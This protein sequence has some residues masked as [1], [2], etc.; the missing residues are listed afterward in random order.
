M[1]NT[2]VITILSFILSNSLQASSSDSILER[3]MEKLGP[4]LY[5]N[6]HNKGSKDIYIDKVKIWFSTCSAK[7]GEPDRIYRIGRTNRSYTDLQS[8]VTTSWNHKGAYCY[9]IDSNFV[10]PRTIKSIKPKPKSGSQK[11]LDKIRGN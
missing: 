5:L 8:T 7:S 6:T 9:N 4:I 2:F 1:K 11:W 10:K 3:D